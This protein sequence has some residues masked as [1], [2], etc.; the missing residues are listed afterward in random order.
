MPTA[1][2]IAIPA[3]A[4]IAGSIIAGKS[5][6]KA[7]KQQRKG[8][9]AAINTMS[10]YLGPYSEAGAAGLPGVQSFVDEGINYRDTQAFKDIINSRKAGVGSGYGSGGRDTALADYM[11]TNFRPQRLNELMQLPSLGANAS[12]AMATGIGGLQQNIGTANAA[13]TIGAGNAW[14][15]GINALGATDFSGLWNPTSLAGQPQN[16]LMGATP[17]QFYAPPQQQFGTF[18]TGFNK[19]GG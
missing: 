3:V 12:N 9:E 13:G 2:A 15:G 17:Q 19:Y 5:A 1:A 10:Q 14:A 6:K 18:N 8:Q 4:G 7:A 11:M 16:N